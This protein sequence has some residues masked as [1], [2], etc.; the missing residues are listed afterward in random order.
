MCNA[1]PRRAAPSR[2]ADGRAF[3]MSF[4]IPREQQKL[5]IEHFMRQTLDTALGL[6]DQGRDRSSPGET[7]HAVGEAI[8]REIYRQTAETDG[9]SDA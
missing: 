5:F 1:M 9:G 4:S 6:V 2:W 7:I 8:I 3:F